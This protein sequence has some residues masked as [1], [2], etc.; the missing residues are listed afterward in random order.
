LEHCGMLHSD[1]AMEYA[2][3]IDEIIELVRSRLA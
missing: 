3:E 1:Q 2:D